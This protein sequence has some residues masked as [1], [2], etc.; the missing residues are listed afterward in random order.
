[1]GMLKGPADA[2]QGGKRGHSNMEHWESTGEIKEAARKKRRLTAKRQVTLGL[3][4]HE[5]FDEDH[6]SPQE[7]DRRLILATN[8]SS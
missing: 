7:V 6:P 8:S 3:A 4:E 5:A 2:G 1:M